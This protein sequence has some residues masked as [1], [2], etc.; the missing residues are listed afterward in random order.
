[1]IV[2]G[3]LALY[4]ALVFSLAGVVFLAYGVRTRRA[5][6]IR[7]GYFA[8]YGFF[9]SVVVAS[10]VLLSAFVRGDFSF[11]YVADNSA[12]GLSLFYRVAG[13][14][15]GAQGSFLLWLLF[16]AIVAT[17][18]A[19][20]NI[21]R[22]DRLT[23]GAVM[24]L[25]VISGFF[26]VLLVADQASNPFVGAGASSG[27]MGLNPLLLHPAMVL[28]PP[29]LFLGYVGL[30]V[31]FAFAVSALLVGRADRELGRAEPEVD[32]RR[33][34]DAVAGH[35]PR[36][37]V[38]VHGA[39]VGRLLGLGPGRE[40]VADAVAHRHGAAALDEPLSQARH[41]QALDGGPG[42]RARSG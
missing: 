3:R 31:P 15:A 34:G 21:E 37:L 2:L 6:F 18:I 24:V 7:N 9:F 42:R 28:H 41:L 1:M 20:R 40:H 36:R 10:A 5:E 35:R 8:V 39:V 17:V 19:L 22:S 29:S 32:D 12:T 23:G 14:W 11:Q 30:A 38:G 27:G 25:M 33:L 26:S 13:F 16:L 4:S